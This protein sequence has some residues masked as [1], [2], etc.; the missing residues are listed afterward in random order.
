MFLLSVLAR[1]FWEA[2][3]TKNILANKPLRVIVSKA[4]LYFPYRTYEKG[5]AL[6]ALVTSS[7]QFKIDAAGWSA[8]ASY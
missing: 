6:S 2:L 4:N 1:N 3:P 5:S 8:R 7:F